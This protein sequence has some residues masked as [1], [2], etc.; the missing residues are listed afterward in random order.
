MNSKQSVFVL[1]AG[2][3]VHYGF[4]TGHRLLVKA[5]AADPIS[6]MGNAGNQVTRLES[7][8][9]NTAIMDNMLEPS[10]IVCASALR[11]PIERAVLP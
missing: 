1:G 11:G 7:Q 9:F 4:S 2:A 3:N 6:L 5:R 10:T 8:H